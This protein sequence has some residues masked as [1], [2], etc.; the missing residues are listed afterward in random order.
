MC[1]A[2]QTRPLSTRLWMASTSSSSGGTARPRRSAAA[3]RGSGSSSWRA[4]CGPAAAGTAGRRSS[5]QSCHC[6]RTSRT[7]ASAWP[8]RSSSSS[9]DG[10]SLASSSLPSGRLPRSKNAP[11]RRPAGSCWRSDSSMLMRSMP[12]VYSAIRGSGM[13]TSS[14]ILKALVCLLMAAV[15]LRSSQNF[16]R[17]SGLMA[18][19]PSPLRE[20]AMRTT[21][22]VARATASGRRRRCRPPAPSWAGRRACSWWSSPPPSGSGRPGAPGRPAATPERPFSANMKSRISTMLGTASLALPKNSRHTV[23]VCAGMRC[24]TQR[25]L[26]IRPSQPSFWMPGRPDRNL[27]V[28]SL[29]RPSLR[30]VWP[31]I[32]QRLAPQFGLAVAAK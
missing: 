2:T 23:R 12:S 8:T 10:I 25:A 22:D 27:S 18:M 30:K 24:T 17:A 16:L 9:A 6:A 31:G 28:T 32:V 20:L 19:K 26:V 1:S 13:T 29:P 4:G 21:S 7:S 11:A 5:S 14:L 15:R 3:A